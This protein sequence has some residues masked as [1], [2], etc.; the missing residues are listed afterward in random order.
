[1][2]GCFV[3][4]V[5]ESGGNADEL[6]LYLCLCRVRLCIGFGAGWD[7][8]GGGGGGQTK[9]ALRGLRLTPRVVALERSLRS[10]SLPLQHLL[11]TNIH[12]LA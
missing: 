12:I 5:G 10:G 1:M 9:A 6:V 4:G 8:G 11:H 3:G 7:I 2:F